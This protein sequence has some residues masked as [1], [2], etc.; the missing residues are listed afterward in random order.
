VHANLWAGGPRAASICVAD[1]GVDIEEACRAE[2]VDF[3]VT[4]VATAANADVVVAGIHGAARVAVAAAVAAAAAAAAAATA[5][6]QRPA[7]AHHVEQHVQRQCDL[8]DPA[9]GVALRNSAS[10]VCQIH[11]EIRYLCF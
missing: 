1:S 9:A 11:K 2:L 7:L 8:P 10:T 6:G 3:A 5:A 4:V